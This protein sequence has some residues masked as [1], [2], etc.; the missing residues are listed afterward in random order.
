MLKQFS[1]NFDQLPKIG[2]GLGPRKRIWSWVLKHL[3]T[4][5]VVYN[6]D[7]EKRML[8][9]LASGVSWL[10]MIPSEWK[11]IYGALY[12]ESKYFELSKSEL[13]KIEKDVHRTFTLFTRN[14]KL[15][16]LQFKIAMNSYYKALHSVLCALSH[17]VGYCQGINFLAAIFLIYQASEKESFI[18][19]CYLLKQC[20]LEILY[21][22]K[23]SSLL[24]YMNYFEKR[25][26]I[27]NKII[28]KYF[29]KINY[30]T[31]CYAIE[32]FTTCFIVT[33]PGEL[34]SCVI[35]LI[36]IGYEDI[37]IRIGLGLLDHLQHIILQLDIEELQIRFKEIV[38]KADP[39]DIMLRVMKMN[40]SNVRKN[41]L[42]QMRENIDRMDPDTEFVNTMRSKVFDDLSETEN[43]IQINNSTNRLSSQDN[44]I[45]TTTNNNNNHHKNNRKI[46]FKNENIHP[47]TIENNN[48]NDDIDDNNHNRNNN[49]SDDYA[50]NEKMNDY[51][52][53]YLTNNHD[54]NNS[55]LVLNDSIH[56]N[57]IE[58]GEENNRSISRTAVNH[59]NSNI[60]NNWFSKMLT[61]TMLL[62]G[63]HHT[64]NNNDEKQDFSTENNI[65]KTLQNNIDNYVNNNNNNNNNNNKDY[66]QKE[67]DFSDTE[68]LNINHMNSIER[69]PTNKIN[70]NNTKNE[71][72]ELKLFDRF[73]LFNPFLQTVVE[74]SSNNDNDINNN[75]Y[76]IQSNIIFQEAVVVDYMNA[77]EGDVD[78]IIV[79][80]NNNNNNRYHSNDNNNNNN[81]IKTIDIINYDVSD[82]TT[83]DSIHNNNS[84][85]NNNNN[86]LFGV[87]EKHSNDNPHNA[88]QSVITKIESMENPIIT[89]D[90]NWST[91]HDGISESLDKINENWFQSQPSNE[92]VKYKILLEN[93]PK[94]L[95]KL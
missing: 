2:P 72:N 42:K 62:I 84:N 4:E 60:N 28:Y 18:I 59:T 61:D 17:Q 30:G 81:N 11:E 58:N 76:L 24:E 35:D 41:V 9:T 91:N 25:L 53:T 1:F 75:N 55:N 29:K 7:D 15:M 65:S 37:M 20:D 6:N 8:K 52:R 34:S 57:I 87:F 66:F 89:I 56:S 39:N 95:N 36:L 74:S 31:V 67:D 68:S 70:K 21:N 38:M 86:I 85:N 71:D 82:R 83:F 73:P 45:T 27:H 46:R 32:W 48:I 92:T 23:C 69:T 50:D 5:N 14:A 33:N 47:K 78:T 19:L 10:D 64:N 90:E 12:D 16:R 80:N 51:S 79:N 13:I 77:Y 22:P 26:R 3:L 43:N 54:N 94:T 40:T 44:S 93:Y 88:N 49:S 63:G